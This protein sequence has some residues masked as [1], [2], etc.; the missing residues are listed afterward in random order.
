MGALQLQGVLPPMITPFRENGDPDAEAFIRNIHRWN[1]TDLSGYLVLG[2]NSEAGYLTEEEKLELIRLTVR[3]AKPGRFI[4]AG[5]GMESTGATIAL[6]E[7]AASLGVHAALVLTPCYYGAQMTHE[8]LVAHFTKIA[9]ASSI[10]ILI[11]NVPKFTHLNMGLETVR[12]LAEHPNI[13]GIKDSAGDPAQLERFHRNLPDGFRVIAGNAAVWLSALTTGI[14]CGIL[15]ASNCIP[16]ICCRIQ[17]HFR[18]GESFESERL[19]GSIL[20]L[21]KAVTA[22]FGIAGL[23]YACDLLGY[24]GGA[25]RSPLLP[26]TGQA[27]E[28]IR[29]ILIAAGV[30]PPH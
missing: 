12:H 9:D 7:K 15:A 20:P 11:Y 18:N 3:E 5:T 4:M 24:E 13:V 10:P 19:H 27:K 22:T 2:S 14:S 21:N 6:T 17:E 1:A 8:A 23:K 16:S 25:V 29:L 26:I 28:D 30:L